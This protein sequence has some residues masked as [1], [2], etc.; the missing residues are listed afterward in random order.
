MNEVQQ[1][2]PGFL[3]SD[4]ASDAST[5]DSVSRLRDRLLSDSI[6]SQVKEQLEAITDLATLGDAGLYVLMQFLRDRHPGPVDSVAGR[7]YQVLLQADTP[8]TRTFIASHYPLG[9]VSMPSERGMDYS[10]LQ[11]LLAEQNYQEADRLTL[12][13]MCELAGAAA[14]QRKWLY[15]SEVDSFPSADLQTIDQLWR[16]FSGDRFGFSIQ[17]DLWL[18]VNKDWERLWPRI[19]WKSGNTWT[20]Y[21]NQFT[22]DLTAPIGHLPLSNQLRGV[23]VMASLMNHPAW[24]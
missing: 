19:G 23:R 8:D 16:V 14:V 9:L 3:T 6:K 21:P 24:R 18:A 20:R 7:A 22:W 1:P 4:A 2:N 11:T 12:Q 10:P 17:R 5:N 13:K 15:F